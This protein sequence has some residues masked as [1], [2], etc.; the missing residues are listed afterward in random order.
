MKAWQVTKHGT[1]EDMELNEVPTPEPGPGEILIKN[2]ASGL[3]FFDILQAAGKHQS[4]APF[5]FTIGAE[6]A[7]IVESVGEGVDD[8]KPGDRVLSMTPGGGYAE[9]SIGRSGGTFPIPEGMS[10]EEA[11]AM[12]VVY[13]TSWLGLVD[14]ANLA[15]G[16]TLLVH[17]GASGVGISAIEIGKH[18]G[19]TVIATASTQEKLDF[20]RERGADHTFNYVDEDWVSEVKKFPKGGADV[21]YD[22]V[23]G[24]IFDLS[25]KCI[26]PWG[27]LLVVGFASGRIPEIAAN[28]IL[29]KQMSVVGVFWGR[30][31]Q[32]DPTYREKTHN[33]LCEVYKA[34]GIK[35]PVYKTYPL[36]EAVEALAELSGRKVRGKV[37][38]TM[39]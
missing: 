35:P 5:P 37:L 10:F 2:R 15:A 32:E 21:I 4:K 19:A 23:G 25:S 13:Q 1:P 31:C 20:C 28:R 7:G 18:L 33:K 30:Q 8:L 38:L 9:Y 6:V 11:A 34:G 14:R 16:E 36:S 24:D 12:P 17:A 3:N 26:A 39:D 22:P 29:L 27:R